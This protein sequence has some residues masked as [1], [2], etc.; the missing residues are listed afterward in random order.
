MLNP[1]RKPVVSLGCNGKYIENIH[2]ELPRVNGHHIHL[3]HHLTA[4]E[5]FTPRQH[6]SRGGAWS[7][8]PPLPNFKHAKRI[9]SYSIAAMDPKVRNGP[10]SYTRRRRIVRTSDSLPSVTSSRGCSSFVGSILSFV[11]G[12]KHRSE[13][14]C[15]R[16]CSIL[17]N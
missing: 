6:E 4:R 15:Q 10:S 12:S 5:L 8:S 11:G 13:L 3:H 1:F 7:W 16:L 9:K 14:R 17:Q 2:G